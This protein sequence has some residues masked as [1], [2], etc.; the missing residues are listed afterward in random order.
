MKK[1][2]KAVFL[3]PDEGAQGLLGKGTRLS[4]YAGEIVASCAM[5][6]EFLFMPLIYG[7]SPDE[8]MSLFKQAMLE[9][10]WMGDNA[11]LAVHE[12]DATQVMA[13]AYEY[14]I[15]TGLIDDADCILKAE[16]TEH[17]PDSIPSMIVP[18]L[19]GDAQATFG[20]LHFLPGMLG[21]KE[22]AAEK[23][24]ADMC[25]KYMP[26]SLVIS[27]SHGWQAYSPA[28]FPRIHER[29]MAI[30]RK[31]EQTIGG[32]LRSGGD[33]C[34]LI[35][36][37]Q[38]ADLKEVRIVANTKSELSEQKNDDQIKAWEAVFLASKE[39]T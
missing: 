29:A 31:A 23:W 38:L 32:R 15:K 28:A 37:A 12:K 26:Q 19:N 36:A 35:A 18:I 17:P 13:Y 1:E 3:M 39:V 22:E 5:H 11:L 16:Y 25:K 14:I 8:L 9:Y 34:F 6:P 7:A 30:M 21:R 2:Y 4:G 20:N 10:S 24:M 33:L 27:R